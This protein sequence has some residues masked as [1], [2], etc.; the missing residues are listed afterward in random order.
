M[1][2][3]QFGRW[4]SE[5]RRAGG[6]SS[7]RLLAEAAQGHTLLCQSGISEDFLS[8]LEAGHLVYPFRGTVRRRILLLTWL[9]CKTP[10]DLKT[11]VKAAGLNDRNDD[12]HTQLHLLNEH[13]NAQQTPPPLLLP[14][15]PCHL[16]GREA[17]LERV[18]CALSSPET[19]IFALTGMPG[20]GKSAL[21]HEVLHRLAAAESE[22]LRHFPDGIVTFTCTGR[23]GTH[24]LISLLTE[25]T[26]LFTAGT[27][28][29]QGEP[30]KR[31]ARKHGPDSTG[32]LP[33]GPEQAEPDLASAID[34]ARAA[35]AN[36]RAL[37]LLDD[38]DP[39]FPLREASDVLLAQGTRTL[40]E[41]R[42]EHGPERR[43]I[44]TTSQFV[45]PPTLISAR[46]QVQPLSEEA[47]LALLSELI[48]EELDE[49]DPVSTR[50]ACAA[51]GYLPLAIEGIAT[52]V[53]ANGIPPSLVMTHLTAHP[54]GG[55]LGSE[56][57]VLAR[58]EQALSNLEPEIR[59]DYLLLAALDLPDFDLETATAVLMPQRVLFPTRESTQQAP[60]L[61][62]EPVSADGGD[63]SSIVPLTTLATRSAREQGQ[64]QLAHLA[65]TAAILGQFVRSSLL[66]LTPGLSGNNVHYHMHTL[67]YHYARERTHI[68]PAERLELAHHN[69]R[70]HA[71]LSLNRQVG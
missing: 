33:R 29:G 3:V 25:I 61:Y 39:A 22:R 5:R 34:H 40:R 41:T 30:L 44:L 56:K 55:L 50:Q 59:A 43:V 54:L 8:R 18:I 69:L 1:N 14:A 26:T 4:F 58:M 19:H 68:L 20:V 49:L 24:G 71:L 65:S 2:A 67:L 15:R 31:R 16:K 13:L 36:K 60:Q 51:V 70:T 42:T 7:Q 32:E 11:Y 52:A 27:H 35:L 6:W 21:A 10:R 23:Q 38:L 47:A 17:E 63:A 37:F 66:E 9:L 62:P 46:L 53:Q 64:E 48:G 45:P 57:E 12:E 28:Q